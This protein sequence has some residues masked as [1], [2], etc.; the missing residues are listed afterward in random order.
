MPDPGVVAAVIVVA[1]LAVVV[2]AVI[3]V[4]AV[5]VFSG[6]ISREEEAE[7]KSITIYP[8]GHY[9]PEYPHGYPYRGYPGGG[10]IPPDER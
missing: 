3:V 6:R 10:W 7:E 5:F 9:N 2:V 8:A 4:I 1:V